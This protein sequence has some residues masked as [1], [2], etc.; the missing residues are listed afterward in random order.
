[1]PQKY[2]RE[3]DEILSRFDSSSSPPPPSPSGRVL[4]PLPPLERA[5]GSAPRSAW[6]PTLGIDLSASNLMVGAIALAVLSYPLQWSYPPAV[7][8][9]GLAAATMLVASVLISVL[10]WNRG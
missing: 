6:R 10:K 2:E 3:I 4:T 9:V 7:A 5:P 1:M 8:V